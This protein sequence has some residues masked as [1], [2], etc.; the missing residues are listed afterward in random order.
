MPDISAWSITT[1]RDGNPM[2]LAADP[3]AEEA[4]SALALVRLNPAAKRYSVEPVG[5]TDHG[6]AAR[7]AREAV[8]QAFQDGAEWTRVSPGDLV[9][10]EPPAAPKPE[11]IDYSAITPGNP[12][13]AA[14]ARTLLD[15]GL[16]PDRE[17]LASV[18]ERLRDQAL[19]ESWSLKRLGAAILRERAEAAD[20]THVSALH[21]IDMRDPI[22]L[23]L[24]Q[25]DAASVWMRVMRPPRAGEVTNATRAGF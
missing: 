24:G 2:I 20:A 9:P 25:E 16:P 12:M 10:A 22:S 17:D 6:F 19:A 7:L 15:M 14:E 13:W 1:D 4:R 5:I 11:R 8:A 23:M 18:R 3:N 21:T